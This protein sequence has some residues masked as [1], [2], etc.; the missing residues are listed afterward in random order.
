MVCAKGLAKYLLV[1][2]ENMPLE[3][4]DALEEALNLKEYH[5]EYLREI[6]DY[7]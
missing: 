7:D 6:G 5:F 4:M 3:E 2:V 1:D